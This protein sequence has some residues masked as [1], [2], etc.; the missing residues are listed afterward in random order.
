[1]PILGTIIAF[2]SVAN[3]SKAPSYSTVVAPILKK[4]CLSCHTGKDSAAGLDLSTGKAIS[5][6]KTI[7]AGQADKSVFLRR[8]KGLDGKPQM[9]LGFKPLTTGEIKSLEEWINGGATIDQVVAKHWAY[10]PPVAYPVPAKKVAWGNNAIDNFTLEKMLQQG[11]K[12]S[13]EASPETLVRRAYLDITGLPPTVEQIDAYLADKNPNRYEKLIDKLLA[14]PAY[15]ER[16]ARMW[17]DLSRYADTD[18]YEADFS[19]TAYL[20]RDWLINAFNKN[21]PYDQFTI[22][23]NAGDMLPNSKVEQKVATGFHRNS[24]FNQ[25]GGVDPKE[26]FYTMVIDRVTTTSQTWL[27]ST[28]QCAQCHNHKYDPFTQKDFFRMYAIFSNGK[29]EKVGD[30]SKSFSEKWFEPKIKVPNQAILMAIKKEEANK[31]AIEAERDQVLS[32]NK[33][34]FEEWKAALATKPAYEDVKFASTVSTAGAIIA[35]SADQALTVTG[36]NPDKDEYILSGTGN[37][38]N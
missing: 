24:Q 3:Q 21:M 25:E 9:P 11:Y 29:Y 10:I 33:A 28:M 19:R 13:P 2:V 37:W 17:L 15:G 23:Q 38:Q 30:Y 6:T 22:E 8:V 34:D 36:T 12:P 5:L 1:M 14:S 16:Q 26:S 31:K 4:A 18:G 20:Y 7:L 35:Q 27:G 32:A